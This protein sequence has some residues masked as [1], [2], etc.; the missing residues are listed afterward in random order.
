MTMATFPPA[1][2]AFGLNDKE[3]QAYVLLLSAGAAPASAVGARLGIPK[4]TARYVCRELAR[5]GL[6]SYS[7][8]GSVF[9]YAAEA[10]EKILGRLEQE[11]VSL[12]RRQDSARKLV[13]E[14]KALARPTGALPQVR[15]YEGL[16]GV[17]EA[18]SSM[19]DAVPDGGEIASFV[20][21]MDEADIAH[22]PPDL[23]M[24]KVVE[25]FE[26]F[27]GKRLRKGIRTRMLAV[28][29]PQAEAWLA[30]DGQ[31]LRETRLLDALPLEHAPVEIHLYGDRMCSS[32]VE[33][34]TVFA[35]VLQHAGIVALHRAVFEHAWNRAEGR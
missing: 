1:L 33:R 14:L 26:N 21:P 18:I 15:F 22:L 16:A 6:V 2:R 24:E 10:P 23:P 25:V 20:R 11:Q 13:G 7:R 29:S 9:L 4:S 34:G 8:K 17:S 28:R 5:K 27:V 32:S 31:D 19:L 12:E 3:A 35:C 30:R